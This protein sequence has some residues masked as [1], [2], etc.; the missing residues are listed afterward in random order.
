MF[1]GKVLW[2]S[3]TKRQNY[4]VVI[5]VRQYLRS[6]HVVEISRAQLMSFVK[7]V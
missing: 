7:I 2:P 4:R 1:N 3:P 5:Y 6:S